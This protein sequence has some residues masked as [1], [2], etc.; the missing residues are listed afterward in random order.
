MTQNNY[1]IGSRYDWDKLSSLLG[2]RVSRLNESLTK[3][4]RTAALA[5]GIKKTEQGVRLDLYSVNEEEL[6]LLLNTEARPLVKVDATK[7]TS[8]LNEVNSKYPSRMDWQT[9]QRYKVELGK[10]FTTCLD[11]I[12]TD[13]NERAKAK[14]VMGKNP[15]KVGD[16]I[17]TS[18][19]YCY[20]ATGITN[21]LKKLRKEMF[22]YSSGSFSKAAR[23]YKVSESSYWLE[24]PILNE[25]PTGP[26]NWEWA[27]VRFDNLIKVEGCNSNNN[28]GRGHDWTIPYEGNEDAME[29]VKA[30]TPIRF[31]QSDI[32]YPKLTEYKGYRSQ[33]TESD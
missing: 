10:A 8:L 6:N 5:K 12:G 22:G 1:Y 7:M 33:Y 28:W 11:V 29:F 3:N 32:S 23:V 9:G 31:S 16:W 27:D 18:N 4:L 15:Y 26:S 25:A 17:D 20:H 13:T 21:A 30:K 24:V 14:K 2:R 19:Q